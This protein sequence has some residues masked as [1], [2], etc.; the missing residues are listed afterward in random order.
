MARMVLGSWVVE[1]IIGDVCGWSQVGDVSVE[2]F[3]GW[4]V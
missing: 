4:K 1:D 3:G 2:G